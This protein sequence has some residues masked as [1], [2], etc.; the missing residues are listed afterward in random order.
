M[1][2]MTDAVPYENLDPDTVLDAVESAGFLTNGRLL[3]LN[4]YENRVYQVGVEDERP[5]VVKFYRPGRWSD[6]AILEEHAFS[7]ELAE[8]E[9]PVV[10]PMEV[11]GETL[12]NSAG[13]RFAIFPSCG[14]RWPEL[15][16]SEERRVLG[17]F[18]GRIHM[19]G[20]ASVFRHRPGLDVDR[21]GQ[22]S[23]DWLLENG[24]IPDHLELAYDSVTESLLESVRQ[25]F[26]NSGQ[27]RTLRIHGDCHLGN[28][29]WTDDGPHFVDLDDCVNGPAVQ[30]LWMLLSGDENE[31]RGQLS[32][33]L[34]GYREFADFDPRELWLV[35]A[36]RTLR[37]MHYN[38]WIAKRWED[39]A[40][41]RAFP[42]FTESRTWE[43]HVL[44]L[45]EQAALLQEAPLQV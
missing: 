1:P 5:L 2:A 42:W 19:V 38:A 6:E 20:C 41:P 40:F 26:A 25:R 30:D 10:A 35:E 37:I 43:E 9:I 32:D 39:P 13:Y 45:R 22:A 44:V 36:L 29:L 16:T 11:D 18:L 8:R 17:R 34:E 12:L 27:V 3:A 4:S 14:G 24:W 31:M 21:L 28:I 15:A 23:R 7:M 33:I